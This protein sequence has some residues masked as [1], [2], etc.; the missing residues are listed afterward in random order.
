MKFALLSRGWELRRVPATPG[1]TVGGPYSRRVQVLRA[2]SID[3]VIDVGA[4][5]GQYA[6]NL[7]A[8]GYSG[9]IES[10]EPIPKM[11]SRLRQRAEPEA[12]WDVFNFALGAEEGQLAFNVTRDSVLSSPLFPSKELVTTVPVAHVARSISVPVRRLDTFDFTGPAMLKIDTQGFEHQVL[13]GASG[14][15]SQ[16]DAIDIEMALVELYEGGSSIYDLLPRLHEEGFSVVSI[17]PGHTDP[18]TAQTLDVDV[19]LVRGSALRR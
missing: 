17:D 14:V 11:Y 19:L 1:A 5:V 2:R 8:A 16:I 12:L 3:M 7:L 13:D 4:S 9:R 6:S 10:F 15:M 18:G